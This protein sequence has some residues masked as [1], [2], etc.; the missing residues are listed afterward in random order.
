V[1]ITHGAFWHRPGI[2]SLDDISWFRFEPGIEHHMGIGGDIPPLPPADVV[3]NTTNPPEKGLPVLIV[4]G[5]R[6]FPKEIEREVLRTPCL[7]VC[8]ASWLMNVGTE[9]GVPPEQLVHVPMGLD[10]DRFRI[11]TPLDARP[12]Q[13]GM[14]YNPHPAK[15]WMPGMQVLR[16]VHARFPEMRALVFGSQPPDEALP[17][18]ITFV[19]DPGPEALVE[20]VYNQCRVFVQPSWYEGFGFTAVEAMA[21]GCALVST[22]NGGSADYA[23]PGETALVAPPGDIEQLTDH[24]ETM[25]RDDA[26]RLRL[27]AAGVEH[28]QQFRWDRAAELLEGHLERYIADPAAYQLAPLADVT[29]SE[30]GS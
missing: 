10:H 30:G 28:V 3:F 18:W 13:I 27:A 22:D 8:V 1:H 29:A 21:C 12:L 16:R 26:E 23:L 24:V 15:G 7:K 2:E 20:D 11:T 14:L 5:F 6:M 9:Y 17:S 25:L 4:Q 19:S